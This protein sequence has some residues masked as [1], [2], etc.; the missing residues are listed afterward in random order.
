MDPRGP[1]EGAPGD[2]LEISSIEKVTDVSEN[3]SADNIVPSPL[4]EQPKKMNNRLL[5]LTVIMM[6]ELLEYQYSF[7]YT[8][9]S[10]D[11]KQL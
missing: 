4:C 3:W 9:E 2:P 5:F 11:I 6:S 10:N 1:P 8:S 7:F